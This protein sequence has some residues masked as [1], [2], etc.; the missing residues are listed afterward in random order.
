LKFGYPTPALRKHGRFGR[1]SGYGAVEGSETV[2][3]PDMVIP[4]GDGV[5]VHTPVKV[6]LL[7]GA[8]LPLS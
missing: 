4:D 7:P 5:M 2:T 6:A 8:N 3:D 1:A